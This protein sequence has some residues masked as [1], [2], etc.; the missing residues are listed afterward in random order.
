VDW[1]INRL[2]GGAADDPDLPPPPAPPL[3]PL[4]GVVGLGGAVGALG[5]Y[6][7]SL[8]LPHGESGLPLATL[9]VNVAG[10]LALGV[11]VAALPTAH[12]LRPLLGTGVLGGFT[13]YST[14][15]LEADRLLVRTPSLAVA[16]VGL[17]LLLGLGAASLGLRLGA[18]RDPG[19]PASTAAS[20]RAVR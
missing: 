11:L 18:R 3:L 16:Y 10:C 14:L 5:R 12:W 17:S 1:R 4:I 20:A 13:T 7:A 8:L 6:A 2:V 9:L 15:A 19:P